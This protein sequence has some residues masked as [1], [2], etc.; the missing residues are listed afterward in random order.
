MEGAE[1]VEEA[2]RGTTLSVV[3]RW[4]PTTA[5]TRISAAPRPVS[6]QAASQTGTGPFGISG[7]PKTWAV[8]AVK[9]TN[10]TPCASSSGA[11][12]AGGHT[13]SRRCESPV[14]GAC[15][16]PGSVFLAR[17]RK[18][19]KAVS[20]TIARGATR[21]ENYP[22]SAHCP[23]RSLTNA[24]S[25]LIEMARYS[26]RSTPLTIASPEAAWTFRAVQLMTSCADVPPSKAS[27]AGQI[28]GRRTSCRLAGGHGSATRAGNGKA[29]VFERRRRRPASTSAPATS[30]I[31][32]QLRPRRA[33]GTP[34]R[35]DSFLTWPLPN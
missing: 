34:R 35:R 20:S 14:T 25:K 8:S 21:F 22:T 17:G 10:S 19:K 27:S 32:R 6:S 5:S 11:R 13:S 28:C 18:S 26:T 29:Q 30:A 3:I 12:P 23:P 16:T 33:A 2:A 31:A 7:R 24:A 9:A 1:S 15:S 4:R